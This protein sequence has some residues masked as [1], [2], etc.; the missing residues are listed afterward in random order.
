MNESMNEWWDLGLDTFSDG[1]LLQHVAA[2]PFSESLNWG[3]IPRL[4]CNPLPCHLHQL[5]SSLEQLRRWLLFLC[6]HFSYPMSHLSL[7]QTNQLQLLQSFLTWHEFLYP[8]ASI[9]FYLP[10]WIAIPPIW[11]WIH[12]ILEEKLGQEKLEFGGGKLR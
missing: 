7:S 11:P 8:L 6:L 4:N 2:Y 3:S 10:K 9:S 1:E 12:P 5:I